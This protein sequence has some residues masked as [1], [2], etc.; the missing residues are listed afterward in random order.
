MSSLPPGESPLE[1]AK[2]R[3]PISVLWR[4]LGLP[5]RTGK[6]CRSPFRYEE[7]R[8]PSFSVYDDDRRWKDHATDEGGD[9]AAFL[10][11]HLNVSNEEACRRL[12]EMTGVLPPLKASSR[13]TANHQ[14]EA[15]E[16]ALAEEKAEKRSQWPTFETPSAA[17]IR[18]IAASRDLSEEG[19]AI[20]VERGLLFCADS[21]EGRAWILSDSR[22]IN[23]QG[24]R[25][26]LKP[27]GRLNG[28]KA[29]TLP[30]SIASWPIGL[31]E[32]KNYPAIAFLEGAPDLLAAL[33]LTWCST[34]TP[35][36][37]A[38]GKGLDTVENLAVVAMLGAGNRIP[39]SALPHFAGKRIR[40]FRHEDANGRSAA[41]RW[42]SQLEAAGANVDGF[43][44]AGF[45][46]TDRTPVN[47]LNDFARL[48]PDQWEAERGL[49]ESAFDF[50]LINP[51]GKTP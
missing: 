32:A 48:D 20:A 35:Q 41:A 28:K 17:E 11:K 44:L 4:I 3:F 49:V 14:A 46:Q 27:W 31:L 33:H 12:I 43:S 25:M 40:I 8:H 7:D 23:A 18:T 39:Q 51:D 2:A 45:M 13:A 1:A 6:S 29:W 38:L 15:E 34:A 30:G 21:Q 37:L 47:D 36:T 16:R 10:A 26:D 9:A 24:R 22:R 50:A 42:A 5:G 19:V